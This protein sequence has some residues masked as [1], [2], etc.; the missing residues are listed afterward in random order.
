MAR[1]RIIL[2]SYDFKM[3]Y[4]PGKCKNESCANCAEKDIECIDA[5][6]EVEGE[7]LT[8]QICHKG[9]DWNQSEVKLIKTAQLF[10]QFKL[11]TKVALLSLISLILGL[12]K[13]FKVFK[14]VILSSRQ[15]WTC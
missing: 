15:L 9:P 5:E 10:A 7:H 1:W 6:S 8:N 3:Q 12:G 13:N 2:D 4:R 14:R 11:M